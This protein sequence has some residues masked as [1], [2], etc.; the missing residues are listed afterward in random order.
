MLSFGSIF[1]IFF[2]PRCGSLRSS[3]DW[4]SVQLFF[5]CLGVISL[6]NSLGGVELSLE[7]FVCN[8]VVALYSCF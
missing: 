7:L 3:L 5:G 6:L 1:V 2:K 8:V 4:V